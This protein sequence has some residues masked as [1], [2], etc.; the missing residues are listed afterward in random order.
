[1]C[2]AI[3]GIARKVRCPGQ[4]GNS[5]HD[6]R[7]DPGPHAGDHAK[8][9]PCPV[10]GQLEVERYGDPRADSRSIAARRP[11]RG[12]RDDAPGLDVKERMSSLRGGHEQRLHRSPG[13]HDCSDHGPTLNPAAPRLG[14]I[15]E[16]RHAPGNGSLRNLRC[17]VDRRIGAVEVGT[18]GR[19]GPELLDL[20]ARD[21]GGG[22][23][24]RA[25]ARGED[26]RARY[27][28]P[29]GTR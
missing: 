1:M 22:A 19:L 29:A 2:A 12:E 10:A 20:G 17:V 15:L 11:E 8:G 18:G 14:G 3:S 24:E 23:A 25:E 21:P 5:V 26:E 13:A 6:G 9:Q 28:G 16:L 27:R 7:H 4:L